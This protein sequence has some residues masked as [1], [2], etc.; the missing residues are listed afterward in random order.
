MKY[1]IIQSSDGLFRA[2][3]WKDGKLLEA[4]ITGGASINGIR[5]NIRYGTDQRPKRKF[6]RI[7]G[8]DKYNGGTRMVGP[9][10]FRDHD[11]EILEVLEQ[12]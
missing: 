11:P 9:D 10:E 12:I 1:A 4:V 7:Y 3:E 8:L 6:K 2:F 5:S